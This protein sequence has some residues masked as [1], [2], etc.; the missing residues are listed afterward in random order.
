MAPRKTP[1]PKKKTVTPEMEEQQKRA[2]ARTADLATPG[3]YS[4]PIYCDTCMK[5][6]LQLHIWS[7]FFSCMLIHT[8]ISYTCG[9]S[10]QYY[11]FP[12]LL[13]FM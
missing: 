12:C 7:T 11:I 1:A 3:K 9:W 5:F 2:S 6:C 4:F 8:A 13:G 10:S